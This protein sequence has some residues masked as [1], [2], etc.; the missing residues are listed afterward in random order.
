MKEKDGGFIGFLITLNFWLLLVVIFVFWGGNPRGVFNRVE[1]L[2]K[3]LFDAQ[4]AALI[5]EARLDDLETALLIKLDTKGEVYY[6]VLTDLQNDKGYLIS[7]L[8]KHKH[9]GIYG[10]IKKR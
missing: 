1:D 6:K 7:E 4:Q 5:N 2:R 8:N 10:R 9:K 3:E